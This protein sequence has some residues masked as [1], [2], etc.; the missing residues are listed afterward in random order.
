FYCFSLQGERVGVADSSSRWVPDPGRADTVN[1]G[2]GKTG[3]CECR[4]R[5]ERI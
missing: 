1:A 3:Y 2:S 4:V 5:R